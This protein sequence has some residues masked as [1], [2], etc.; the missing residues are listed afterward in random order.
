[1]L[2]DNTWYNYTAA[3]ETELLQSRDEGKDVSRIEQE[4]RA[5]GINASYTYEDDCIVGKLLD[6]IQALPLPKSLDFNEPSD[7]EGI[8]ALQ[9]SSM[10]EHL[11]VDNKTVADKIYGAWIGRVA[12]CILG[13]PVENW[14][15]DDIEKLAKADDNYPIKHYIKGDLP[16][17]KLGNKNM[18]LVFENGW[19]AEKFNGYAAADDDTNYTVLSLK[20]LETYGRNYSTNDIAESWLSNFPLLCLCTAEH[21]A[22]RNL[23]NH[24]APPLC[25]VY[26]NPYREWIGAQIRG[27]IFGYINPGNPAG[28]AEMAY[29]DGCMTHVKNGIYGEMFIAAMIA[30]AAVTDNIY[31][32]VNAGLGVIPY[33]S[34]LYKQIELLMRDFQKGMEYE[35]CIN[36]IYDRYPIT[37]LHNSVHTIPNALIVVA[38]LLYGGGDF[39]K[40]IG[41][42]VLSGMDTDCNG[43]TAGSVVGMINGAQKIDRVWTEPLCDTLKTDITGY[44]D[45]KISEMAQ[46]TMNFI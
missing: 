15:K 18:Q 42:A 3:L 4:V 24:I 17:L 32:I 6:K 41:L 16:N 1:M 25:A 33:T 27:D 43:A 8:R 9:N 2:K 35:T 12:G 40:T 34:R 21:A 23:V 14:S 26:R 13:K 46:R 20:I 38:S 37:S 22:Y 10:I 36:R 30:Q 45:V 5:V 11:Q 31:S 7:I 29:R 39:T 44:S 28:A 19:F